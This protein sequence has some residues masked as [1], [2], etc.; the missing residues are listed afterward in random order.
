MTSIWLFDLYNEDCHKYMTICNTVATGKDCPK[1][2][3]ARNNLDR[4]WSI[5][6]NGLRPYKCLKCDKAF[7]YKHILDSHDR[8]HSGLKPYKCDICD[9]DFNQLNNLKR[10]KKVTL[11]VARNIQ[12]VCKQKF[13]VKYLSSQFAI[14]DLP[15]LSSLQLC[16]YRWLAAK[17]WWSMV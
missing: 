4:H 2:F 10:H 14:E 5:V 9:R 13:Q 15:T 7:A 6:H 1:M 11:F 8:I 12:T 17:K 16:S 3:T